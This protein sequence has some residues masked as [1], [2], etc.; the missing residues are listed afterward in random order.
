MSPALRALE[1]MILDKKMVHGNHPVLALCA[2]NSVI[3][4]DP[5]GNRKLDKRKSHGRID[6]MVS[7][8][9][10]ASLAEATT[11]EKPKEYKV[12]IF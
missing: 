4:A 1:Q 3:V 10:A 8:A 2:A 6:G 12:L 5:A 11:E 7:L 9:M